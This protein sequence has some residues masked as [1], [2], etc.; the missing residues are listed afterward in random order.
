[1]TGQIHIHNNVALLAVY[2]Y[3]TGGEEYR[4]AERGKGKKKISIME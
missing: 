1:L 4:V 2:C 3:K